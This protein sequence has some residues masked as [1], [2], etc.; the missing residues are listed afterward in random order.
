MYIY[1]Y[2]YIY[3]Y[4]HIFVDELRGFNN[5]NTQTV[6]QGGGANSKTDR[7]KAGRKQKEPQTKHQPQTSVVRLSPSCLPA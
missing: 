4:T 5:M 3:V 7:P 1:I 2:I 6:Q